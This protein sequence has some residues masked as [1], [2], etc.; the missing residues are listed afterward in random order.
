MKQ[1]L[2][3]DLRENRR[4]KTEAAA[5]LDLNRSSFLNRLALLEV[6][7]ATS[8]NSRHESTTWGERWHLHWTP[9][10]E[11]ALVES[12]LLGETVELAAAFKF[13]TRLEACSNVG[14]AAAMIRIA[15]EC[16]MMQAMQQA[17]VRLQHLAADTSEFAAVAHAAFELAA[18]VRYGDVR[19]FDP[20]PMVPLVQELF[21]QG[22]LALLSAANCDNEAAKLIVRGMDEL[23]KVGLEYHETVDEASWV[24]RLRAL[25]D[26]DDRNPLVSGY[27]CAMLLERNELSNEQLGREVSRRLS[28]G[29]EAD[30]G[31]GW[32]EGLSMRNRYALLARQVLWEQLSEYVNSLDDEQFS[33][34]LVF[35][36]RAFGGF[37]PSEKRSIAESLGESWGVAGDL[38]SEILSQPLTKEEEASLDG[39]NDF[40]FDDL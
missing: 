37:S 10:A 27:A 35:L 22:T 32:F 3:L 17:R 40:D 8:K 16:G 26:A 25:A 11:I 33:R 38:T 12:V 19:K 14:E 39:L 20:Q 24:A 6:P 21:V 4:A 28:P 34:A 18:V 36:R 15:C 7:F 30:L 31:A 2:T 13:K 1:E 23:N 9:E 5:Y 29:I